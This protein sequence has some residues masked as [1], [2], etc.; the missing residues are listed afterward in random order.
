MR[1]LVAPKVN[2]YHALGVMLDLGF[3]RVEMFKKEQGGDTVLI[4]MKILTTWIEEETLP[5]T[6]WLTLI[7]ALHDMNME[8]LANDITNKLEQRPESN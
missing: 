7:Q 1:L 2:D 5:P 6:T 8:K 3:N 4:N